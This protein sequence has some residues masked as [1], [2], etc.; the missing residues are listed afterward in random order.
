[1]ELFDQF[2]GQCFVGLQYA[3]VFR[4]YLATLLFSDVVAPHFASRRGL[5]ASVCKL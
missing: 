1:M 3:Q 5:A 4:N 2:A